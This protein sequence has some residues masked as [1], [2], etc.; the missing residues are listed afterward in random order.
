ML[1]RS[2]SSM[3][4]PER[5]S[6]TDVEQ[7]SA[8]TTTK[9]RLYVRKRV[10]KKRQQ[11][12]GIL[13]AIPLLCLV[14]AF[15]T[16][17]IK[18]LRKYS[19]KKNTLHATSPSFPPLYPKVTRNSDDTTSTSQLSKEALDMCTR[20]LWHTLETT[21]IVMPDGDSF[22]HTGDMDDLW[23]RDSAAQVHPLLIPIFENGKAE[24]LVAQDA[25]LD[26]I[27]SG[28]IKRTAMY[29]RHDPY[30]NAFRIDDSYVF[31]KAQKKM[32]RH[33]LIS[34]WNYELD[35]AV[36]YLRMLYF[37][38]KTSPNAKSS[39]SVLQLQQVQNAVNI[40]LDL[41][42]AEQRHE[43]DAFPTGPLFDCDNCNKPYRY[44]GLKRNGKGTPTNSTCGLTWTGFRPS[45]DECVYGYLVPANMFA[46]VV[47]EYVVEMATVLW[48]DTA[49]AEKAQKLANEIQRGIEEH[50]IVKGPDDNLIYAYE[51]DG[52]G[53]YLLMDDANVPSLMSIPYLGYK[54]DPEIYANTRRFILSPHNPTYVKGSNAFTGEIEG[55]GSPHMKSQIRDNIWPMALAIQ[56]LTS[57]DIEEKIH[58]VETLVKASAGTGWMHESFSAANPKRFT[59]SWFCWA[60]SLFAELVLSLTD[61]CPN[62]EHKYN[63]LEWRDTNVV[64]GGRFALD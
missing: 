44:P 32:G 42:I 11:G 34:T 61:K 33:D 5:P 6:E 56:G 16:I 50:A 43:E 47:L 64:P 55:Y 1:R 35:S 10:K 26:R 38:W 54:Y 15:L 17:S 31:S 37:Y 46:V 4:S 9:R 25:K 3:A 40:M 63:V 29:I 48:R 30:A 51:V 18:V 23:L 53:N 21:T 28:L 20:T 58:I 22:V 49:M 62:P 14:V 24:A 12:G 57:D 45:D 7:N 2:A 8:A 60:D 52:L 59:R 39:E 27:V 19:K 13:L 41:W 36:Y